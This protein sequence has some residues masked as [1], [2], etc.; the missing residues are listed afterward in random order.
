MKLSKKRTLQYNDAMLKQ[1][2][3]TLALAATSCMC[4]CLFSCSSGV[5]PEP[6]MKAS[7]NRLNELVDKA[8]AVG[9]RVGHACGRAG[10]TTN[11]IEMLI[12]SYRDNQLEKIIQWIGSHQWQDVK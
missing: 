12:Q 11:E 1:L 7:T 8:F 2:T 4:I 9:M 10:A 5:K 3:T 6:K